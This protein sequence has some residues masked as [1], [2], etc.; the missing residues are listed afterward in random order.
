MVI[1][2]KSTTKLNLSTYFKYIQCVKIFVLKFKKTLSKHLNSS[3]YI[4]IERKKEK[5]ITDMIDNMM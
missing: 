2:V 4:E 1:N 3:S 5:K